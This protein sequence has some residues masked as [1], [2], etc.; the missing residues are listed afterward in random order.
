VAHWCIDLNSL[1]GKSPNEQ[2]AKLKLKDILERQISG[3]AKSSLS[4]YLALHFSS[5]PQN[6]FDRLICKA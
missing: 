5:A 2:I 6:G 4:F 3:G 1:Q